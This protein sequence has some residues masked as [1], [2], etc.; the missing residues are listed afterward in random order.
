MRSQGYLYARVIGW[1]PS[2]S[3]LNPNVPHVKITKLKRIPLPMFHMS[4]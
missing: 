4:R 1:R 3:R 2:L